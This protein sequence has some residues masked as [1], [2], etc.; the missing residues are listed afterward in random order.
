MDENLPPQVGTMVD[1]PSKLRYMQS[2]TYW[3]IIARPE[4]NDVNLLQGRLDLGM[5]L[6]TRRL[7]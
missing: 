7:G 5:L 3:F 2:H 1:I 4:F 6:S